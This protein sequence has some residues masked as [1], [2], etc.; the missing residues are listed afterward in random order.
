MAR[1]NVVA[2]SKEANYTF[3]PKG[4]EV[5]TDVDYFHIT[6]NNTIYGTEIR[7]DFDLP[8]RLV[9][10]MSSDIFS[11]PSTCRSMTHLRRCPEE[12]VACRRDICHRQRGRAGTRRSRAAH[13]ARLSHSHQQGLDVQHASRVS[14]SILPLQ[15]LKWYELRRRE[16]LPQELDE[17]KA[18]VLYDAI[19]KSRM[20][21]GTVKPEDRSIMNVCFVMKPEY[22]E[23]EKDFLDFATE[24]GIVGI[25][26][27]PQLGRIPCFAL[28]RTA[29]RQREGA[30]T[31]H[32]RLRG[33]TL[34]Q[35]NYSAKMHE[36]IS[37]NRE[38]ILP[39]VAVDS[40]R[41]VIE[42]GVATNW[43]CSSAARTT[44]GSAVSDVAGLIVRSD[45]VDK[46]VFDAAPQLKVV[47]RAG[48]G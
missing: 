17:E 30:H 43:C 48:A 22:K 38:T 35:T 24:R 21:V 34:I 42:E 23:L 14:P 31:S 16:A 18:A 27:P 5:P 2:S 6:T 33:K 36:D 39:Q 45:K 15:T 1:V 9:A 47:V 8:V 19:D 41:Q 11:R 28:H 12:C 10:D 4:Y 37:S 13:D 20:F 3:I 29:I 32:A 25:K 26:V 44:T 7:K 46:E 40:I